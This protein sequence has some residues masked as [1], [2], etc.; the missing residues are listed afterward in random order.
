MNDSLRRF[1]CVWIPADLC[2][3]VEIWLGIAFF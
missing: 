3:L 1:Q 2:M